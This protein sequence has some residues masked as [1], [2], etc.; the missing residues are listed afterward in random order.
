MPILVDPAQADEII[1]RAL[2][3]LKARQDRSALAAPPSLEHPYLHRPEAWMQDRLGCFLWSKQIEIAQA[4]EQHRRVA[5]PSAHAVSK[6]WTAARLVAWWVAVHPPGSALAVTTAPTES[7]VK[8]ILWREIRRGHSEGQLEGHLN[9]KEW[10][11]HDELVAFGRKPSD[12]NPAGM[13]GLHARYVL[14][15]ID[16][17]GG[18][19]EDIWQAAG[20]L[21]ANSDSRVLAIGNP[22]DPLSYFANVCRPDSGWHVVTVDGLQSPNF[23]GE[24]VPPELAQL[25]LSK[26]YEAELRA[27]VGDEDAVY[28][29]RIRARFPEDLAA[30]VVPLSWARA[31]QHSDASADGEVELGVDVGAGGD[32]TV[33]RERRGNVAGRTGRGKT[34]NWAHGVGMVL[35]AI[36]ECRPRRVKI[37][38][39]GIGYGMVGRLQELRTAGRHQA[40]IVGVNVGAASTTPRFPKLRDQLWWEIGRELSRTQAWNL[41]ACDEATIAQLVAPRYS[42]DSAGRIHIEPKKETKKRLRRSPDDAD[43]LLL[44]FYGP[45]GA[46]RLNASPRA[47]AMLRGA[48][49]YPP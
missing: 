46:S 9:Q 6:S 22:D 34:P 48:S 28:L 30:S 35:E 4:V 8:S 49:F 18:V 31:C 15:V 24:Y 39:V 16:E 29:S 11:L 26:D 7:Q 17:A 33:W 12:Q 43:A 36:D 37:D 14:V 23:T 41:A 32:E 21:A 38:V 47:L 27:E 2:L 40:E 10:Y 25:L 19:P 1:W 42:P 20:S 13:Q 45:P 44:A 3:G 5:V